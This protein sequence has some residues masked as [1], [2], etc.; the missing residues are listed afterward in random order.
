MQSLF[1]RFSRE[2]YRPQS[3]FEAAQAT[4]RP[5]L[6]VRHILLR[7][8]RIGVCL[9]L[10]AGL[11]TAT[12]K[13]AARLAKKAQKAERKGRIVDA[14]LLYSEAAAADPETPFYWQKSLALRTRAATAAHTIPPADPPGEADAAPAP[15]PDPPASPPSVTQKEIEATRQPQPPTRLAAKPGVQT[16]DLKADSKTLW[17]KL[18]HAYGLDVVFDGDYQ[19]SP[20]IRFNIGE[21]TYD[22]ALYALETVTSSF[23]VPVSPKLF[24][25]VKDTPQKRTEVENTVAI[26]IPLPE[27]VTVQEAQELARG[28][29]QLFELTK[30]AVDSGQRLAIIRGPVSK[31]EPARIV[32][33]DLLLHRSQIF[34][35]IEVLSLSRIY[36]NTYGIPITNSYQLLAPVGVTNLF[37][38]VGGMG[39]IQM[40]VATAQMLA[41]ATDSVTKTILRSELRTVDGQAATLRFGDK[42]PIVTMT[43]AGGGVNNAASYYPPPLFQFEDL[44]LSVKATPKVHGDEA[45]T[46]DIELE[47]KALGAGGFNGIPTISNRKYTGRVR[48]EFGEE[49]IVAGLLSESDARTVAGFAG[50]TDIPVVGPLTS[51]YNRHKEDADILVTVKPILVDSPPFEIASHTIWTGTE[52]RPKSP[53]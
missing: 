15:P 52:S 10:V 20:S 44:G 37:Q 53:I 4:Q 2:L 38:W 39:A 29:Q 9:L 33:R 18:A 17:E 24:M 32:F 41:Y 8:F 1:G 23:I 11:A 50:L 51:Q 45:V 7:L 19:T 47:Y 31:V 25:V 27:P 36:D 28:V 46:L 5:R 30:V 48:L 22:Q 43:F 49:A 14:Y 34:L 16:I 6:P 13:E 35:E 12:P 40:T 21:V 3:E 42:Y 26:S